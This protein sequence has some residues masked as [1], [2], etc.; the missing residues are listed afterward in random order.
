LTPEYY[1]VNAAKVGY[2]NTTVGS[3]AAAI[4]VNSTAQATITNRLPF[5]VKVHTISSGSIAVTG[6]VVDLYN[7][8][9]TFTAIDGS[10]HDA[11]TSADGYIYWAFNESDLLGTINAGVKKNGYQTVTYYNKNINTSTQLV[12]TTV[13]YKTA[14]GDDTTAPTITI[15]TPTAGTNTSSTTPTITF[16]LA[17]GLDGSG[18]DASTIAVIGVS[19]FNALA[20]CSGLADGVMNVTCTFAPTALTDGNNY[21][22]NVFTKDVAGNSATNATAT[23]GIDSHN[24][25]TVTAITANKTT[26]VAN[27]TDYW[28]YTFQVTVG[29][30]AGNA[31]RFKMS[32]WTDGAGH[33]IAVSGYATVSYKNVTGQTNTYNIKNAYNTSET[34][35]QLY[36][37]DAITTGIQ[38]VLTIRQIIPTNT[39][40]AS[41][42]STYGI[43]SYTVGV[44]GG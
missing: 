18:I 29:N 41:Y 2:I 40:S 28:E 21:T 22:I 4:R 27:G 19:G 34:I 37:N 7:D 25:I 23:I 31:T 3:V 38:A 26:A 42:S 32:D 5:S 14:E 16:A 43:N 13:L 11:N 17:D 15:N 10:T 12:I 39:A 33:T 1:T 24:T 35:Y 6:S 20:H 44:T 30:T 36:D 8:T 9:N